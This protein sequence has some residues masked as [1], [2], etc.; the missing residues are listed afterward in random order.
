[1]RVG[2]RPSLL[3]CNL[4]KLHFRHRPNQ[5]QEGEEEGPWLEA[6]KKEVI[7]F[8]NEQ[9]SRLATR[10]THCQKLEEKEAKARQTYAV[11]PSAEALERLGR[12]ESM[13]N[14]QLFRAM[15]ELRTLQSERR[16]GQSSK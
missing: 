3:K 11:L 8:L 1:A 10:E 12:Y 15:K 7:T 6:H 5:K 13:L 14:R 4:I 16:E 2:D 9:L